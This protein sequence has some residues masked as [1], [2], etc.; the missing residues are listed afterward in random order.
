MLLRGEERDGLPIVDARLWLSEDVDPVARVAAAFLVVAAGPGFP[1]H[2][3]AATVLADPPEG[4]AALAAFYG[5]ALERV[6]RELTEVFSARPEVAARWDEAIAGLDG[7]ETAEDV[8]EAIWRA[9]FPQ[10]VGILPT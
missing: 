9:L 5:D 7:A 6:E 8:T 4:T 10:A 1:D 3:R 2:E